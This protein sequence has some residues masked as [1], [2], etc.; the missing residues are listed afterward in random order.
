MNIGQQRTEEL[1][2]Q[3]LARRGVS[4]AWGH[5]LVQIRPEDDAVY[6][7]FRHE[8]GE[9]TV[10]G[11]HLVLATGARSEAVRASWGW[12]SRGRPIPTSS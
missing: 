4:I 2:D 6:A 3:A 5:E 1:L 10:Q 11:S 8:G 9:T 7:T 12:A